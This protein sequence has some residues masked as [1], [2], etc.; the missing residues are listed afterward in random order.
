LAGSADPRRDPVKF[1]M[2][3]RSLRHD[4]ARPEGFTLIELLVVIAIIGVLVALLLPAAQA[5]REAARRIHCANN[6]KQN[7]LAVLH[8][9]DALGTL[10]P[11][12]L[13]DSWPL[14]LTWA[15][16]I[17]YAKNEVDPHQSLLGP[18]LEKNTRVFQCPSLDPG[19]VTLLYKGATGGY[20]YNQNLGGAVYPPS[21]PFVPRQ[22]LK[23][24]AEFPSTHRT[25]ILSDSARVQL[26]W[27]GDPVLK[28]TENLYL[29]G[30]NDDFAAPNT[31]FRHAGTANAAFLDGHV[32]AMR[33]AGVPYPGHWPSQA[34]E[35]A[36]KAMIDYLGTTSIDLYRPR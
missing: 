18:F 7:A 25:L 29:Q 10:P 6:L 14:Q 3:M 17:D 27:S 9:H 5:A 34:G 23:R 26:P 12:N 19:Q 21:P 31:H 1:A 4:P 13:V 30:P 22:V 20:G 28:L 35:L 32:E 36:R 8:Y 2:T 24:L 15:G 11:S 33:P 16:L